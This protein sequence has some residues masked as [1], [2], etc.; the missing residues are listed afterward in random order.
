M[1]GAALQAVQDLGEAQLAVE[2]NFATAWAPPM[3]WL[4]IAMA[5]ETGAEVSAQTTRARCLRMRSTPTRPI[6]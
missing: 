6:S 1:K 5:S 2:Y 4:T 3:A